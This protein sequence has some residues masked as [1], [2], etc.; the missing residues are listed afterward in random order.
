MKSHS[1][2][3]KSY[4]LPQLRATRPGSQ[5]LVAVSV[6]ADGEKREINSV[7]QSTPISFDNPRDYGTHNEDCLVLVWNITKGSV[8]AQ[9]NTQDEHSELES[10]SC[11]NF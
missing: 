1:S 5:G 4:A 6:E 2:K 10:I 8:D 11:S 7:G 3:N 9:S